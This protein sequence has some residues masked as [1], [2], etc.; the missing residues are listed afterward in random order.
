MHS[1]RVHAPC[2]RWIPVVGT[3]ASIA[4]LVACGAV[5][6]EEDAWQAELLPPSEAAT[7][8]T[9]AGASD[10]EALRDPLRAGAVLVYRIE[11]ERDGGMDRWWLTLAGPD[12]GTSAGNTACRVTSE[13]LGENVAASFVSPTYRGTLAIEEPS[14]S[15]TVRGVDLP[16]GFLSQGYASLCDAMSSTECGEST[17]TELYDEVMRSFTCS[18]SLSQ[19][20][21]GN[22]AAR[23]LVL[24]L[25][26]TPS[27]WKWLVPVIDGALH[28]DASKA[29]RTSTELGP[30]WILPAEFRLKGDPAFY[31]KLVVVPPRGALRMTGGILSGAGFAP[32]RP[33]EKV[34]WFVERAYFESSEEPREQVPSW[35]GRRN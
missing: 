20:G 21:T 25:I 12:S 15:R 2:L 13:H 16:L 5:K 17:G 24:E 7:T 30:G 10:P 31:A 9:V 1:D 29:E 23:A 33:E 8:D 3:C 22:D 27:W 28:V 6:L 35:M 18:L 32:D 4:G 34:R 19:L 14:G 26:Q 11:R